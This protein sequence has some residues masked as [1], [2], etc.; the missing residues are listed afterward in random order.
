MKIFNI[1]YDNTN[2]LMMQSTLQEMREDFPFLVYKYRN[3]G[4]P[5]DRKILTE[6]LLF[7]ASA[8]SFED[9]DDCH[10][11]W[12]P[13]TIEDCIDH[14]RKIYP[15]KNIQEIEE[16]ARYHWDGYA[17][18][19]SEQTKTKLDDIDKQRYEMFGV[20]CLTK[21]ESNKYLWHQYSRDHNGFCVEFDGKKLA[22]ELEFNEMGEVH[23][24]EE[25]AKT[26]DFTDL[27]EDQQKRI[28]HKKKKYEKEEEFRIIR[29]SRHR[30]SIAERNVKFSVD[31][32]SR[33]IIDSEMDEHNKEEIKSLAEGKYDVQEIKVSFK[34]DSDELFSP[35]PNN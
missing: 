10:P 34:P 29:Y 11:I 18:T 17:I 14:Y 27:Y 13:P 28:Y 21:S 5:N 32:I 20:L 15:E 4:N 23:Y 31:C 2:C 19:P 8:E 33:V 35:L 26:T 6:N 24:H 30:L 25:P 12:V 7:F 16:I 22:K 3:W 1:E 9:K